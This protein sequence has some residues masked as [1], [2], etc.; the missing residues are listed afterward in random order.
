V[1][2]SKRH[3]HLKKGADEDVAQL[4]SRIAAILI[5]LGLDSPRAEKFLRKGF[6]QA[7]L[8]SIDITNQ[9][10][11]QSKVASLTGLS[12]LE[13]RTI[14]RE[15][16]SSKNTHGT[17]ID[18]ILVGWSSDP[19][20]IDPRGKPR[21][22]KMRGAGTSF[23][24]LVRKYGRDITARTIR[25]ELIRRGAAEIRNR[26]LV[27][28]HT[29]DIRSMEAA[30]AQSD[31]R[32]LASHLTG[33]NFQLGRRAYV[34]RQGAIASNDRKNVEMLKR[35]AVTR[36]E[37]VLKSLSELSVDSR[38]ESKAIPKRARRLLVSAIVAT[39]AED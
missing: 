13:V 24:R 30:A 5:R 32:F 33:I 27:L 39:E 18:Q 22:L 6:V 14:L 8:H 11:T 2:A 28:L 20:F 19:Q 12:R 29:S 1:T 34:L 9:R 21:P 23:E 31:L 26:N 25:D 38:G 37:T 16:R 4:L 35:I 15:P 36:I 7:A 3:R 17:R 10:P